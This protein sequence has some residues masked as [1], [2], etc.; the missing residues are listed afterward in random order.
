MGHLRVI[1]QHY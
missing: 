1:R